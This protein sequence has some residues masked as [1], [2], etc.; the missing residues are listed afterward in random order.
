MGLDGGDFSLDFASWFWA[1]VGGGVAGFP[2]VL[3]FLEAI[4]PATGDYERTCFMTDI[5]IDH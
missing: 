2:V 5:T 3:F 4:G 1:L